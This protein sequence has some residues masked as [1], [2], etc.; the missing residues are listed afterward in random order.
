MP[1]LSEVGGPSSPE[2]ASFSHIRL[3]PPFQGP[4][5]SSM[6]PSRNSPTTCHCCLKEYVD[7]RRI[8]VKEGN[9]NSLL[10]HNGVHFPHVHPLEGKRNSTTYFQ[11]PPLKPLS[12]LTK[13]PLSE[14]FQGSFIPATRRLPRNGGYL[15]CLLP[16]S[17]ERV[18]PPL[19]LLPI[20]QRDLQLDL[21]S[22]RPCLRPPGL[23]SVDKLGRFSLERL[24]RARAGVLR[25]FP[26]CGKHST[27]PGS[28]YQYY[29]QS[30][31]G[32]RVACKSAKVN[33]IPISGTHLSWAGMEHNASARLSS[34]FKEGHDNPGDSTP[35]VSS[36]LVPPDCPK[37]SGPA[38]F[39]RLLRPLRKAQSASSSPRG[40]IS[41][42]ECA[43]PTKEDS[44]LGSSVSGLVDRSPRRW[45]LL[46][47][48]R[49]R[50]CSLHG[51]LGLGCWCRH[52][53][54][55]LHESQVGPPAKLLAYQPTRALRSEV[56]DREG[57]G[58]IQESLD[59][60]SNRQRRGSCTDP[61][62]GEPP[63]YNITR[64]NISTT[65]SGFVSEILDKTGPNSGCLQY[66][67]RLPLQTQIAPG[68]ASVPLC[69]QT[70]FQK[71]GPAGRGP[72]C[73]S[74]VDGGSGLRNPRSPRQGG[75]VRGRVFKNVELQTGLGFPSPTFSST[76]STASELG[77]GSVP[78]CRAEMGEDVL[79]TCHK[80]QSYGC[81]DQTERAGSVPN[82]LDHRPPSSERPQPQ[83][84][85]L[86][87]TGWATFVGSWSPSEQ[88]LLSAAWRTSTLNT[89][90]QPWRR[91]VQWASDNSI[92]YSLPRPAE[93]ARFLAHLFSSLHLSPASIRLHKSVICTWI[94]PDVSAAISSHPLILKMLKG[95]QSSCPKQETRRIW[96]VEQLKRWMVNNPPLSSSYFQ[97]ARH[98]SLLLL[99]ASG[100]RIHDLTLLHISEEHF[101]RVSPDIIFWPIFGAKTDSENRVQSGW[102]LS[103]NTSNP[104]WNIVHWIDVLLILRKQRCG[105]LP[106]SDLFLSS[107]GKVKP[108]SRA[109]IAKWIATALKQAGILAT[110][111]SFRSAVNSNLARA[112]V[113]LDEILERANWRCPSTFL[114]HYY[115]QIIPTRSGSNLMDPI[116]SGFAP[117][118]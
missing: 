31:Q 104:L 53:R 113:N 69:Y 63:L 7:R 10:S 28:S 6:S 16:P 91:W 59:N 44:T 76:G 19:S 79:E 74:S 38:K 46:R 82:Q 25:R 72:V 96:D 18:P 3:Q 51:C 105:S 107:R 33:D 27:T 22:I 70:D 9:N 115:R 66:S 90:R 106:F 23:Q 14:S 87:S 48:P 110:P 13:V 1:S 52:R 85:G 11:S 78:A 108:A 67:S 103:P 92:D 20:L 77:L 109:T 101:Q 117:T 29:S 95:I 71:M 36:V 88:Q 21:P 41:S 75:A 94:S 24:G 5:S 34:K 26:Y 30:T 57:P 43:T 81:S 61:K 49:K 114:K 60:P 15:G 65:P 58:P 50:D 116:I 64:R 100:R 99:L 35:L 37:H 4:A 80:G 32:T 111:G 86:E 118:T 45:H 56:G 55:P 93:V 98:V 2:A 39:C 62:T 89:Y 12:G 54:I 68:M 8:H 73:L 42:K 97:V 47:S 40:K 83:I 17:S 112:N 102:R 84:G